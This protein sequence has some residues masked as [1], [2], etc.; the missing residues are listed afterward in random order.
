MKKKRISN[1][2][3]RFL[4]FLFKQ[5]D[6][7]DLI[8]NII[9]LNFNFVNKILNS[10]NNRIMMTKDYFNFVIFNNNLFHVNLM[11]LMLIQIKFNN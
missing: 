7:L 8:T 4:N 3:S 1:L 5:I 6:N 9:M 10:I 2:K 11:I